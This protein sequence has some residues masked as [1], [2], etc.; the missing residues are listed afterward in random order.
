VEWVRSTLTAA[1]P[2]SEVIVPT[3]GVEMEL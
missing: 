1:L 2:G 3:P